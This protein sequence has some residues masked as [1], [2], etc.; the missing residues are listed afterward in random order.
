M[1]EGIV[2]TIELSPHDKGTAYVS[3]TRYKFGD[4]SPSIYKTT[5][6]G[7]SWTKR[8]KRGSMTTPLFELSEKIQ[9]RKIY[10]MLALRLAYIS[11]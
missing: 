11:L 10:F 3:F 9:I 5:N 4:L 2:N 1:N 6:Y 8:V 7:K